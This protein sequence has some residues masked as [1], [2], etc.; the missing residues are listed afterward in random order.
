MTD[1]DPKKS[2]IPRKF[3][4]QKYQQCSLNDAGCKFYLVPNLVFQDWSKT[5]EFVPIGTANN[6]T[7][8]KI[9]PLKL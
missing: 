5:S 4:P 1:L 8:P 9:P 2:F 3:S 7:L 6:N